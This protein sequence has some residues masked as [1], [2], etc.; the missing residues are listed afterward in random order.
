MATMYNKTALNKIKKADLIALFLEQQA[1][2]NQLVLDSEV[3][4]ETLK[5]E[6]K[7]LKNDLRLCADGLIPDGMVGGIVECERE[8]RHKAEEEN[9]K[10]KEENEKLKWDCE[11]MGK[12]PWVGTPA[13]DK[14]LKLIEENKK[15]SQQIDYAYKQLNEQMSKINLSTI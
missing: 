10:L 9:E 3:T 1:E 14:M 15:L 13:C 11:Q 6:N 12:S 7:K 4:D 2:K 5:E 8:K